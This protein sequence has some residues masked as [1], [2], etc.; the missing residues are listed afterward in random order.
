VSSLPVVTHVCFV[1]A[2]GVIIFYMLNRNNNK[3]T[4]LISKR[5]EILLLLRSIHLFKKDMN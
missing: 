4:S 2:L 5:G 3:K 1:Y